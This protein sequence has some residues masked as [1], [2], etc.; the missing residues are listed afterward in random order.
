MRFVNGHP[1]TFPQ[2]PY[3]E[4]VLTSDNNNNKNDNIIKYKFISSIYCCF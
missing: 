1:N 4:S 3:K 2:W